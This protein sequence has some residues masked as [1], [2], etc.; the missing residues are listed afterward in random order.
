VLLIA[1][2]RRQYIQQISRT[3]FIKTCSIFGNTHPAT[4][5]C[6]NSH[7]GFGNPF[8]GSNNINTR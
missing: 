1:A 8:S 5:S 6:G 7:G 4:E 3:V 2:M